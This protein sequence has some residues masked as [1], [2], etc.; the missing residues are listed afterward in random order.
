MPR[1]ICGIYPKLN[2]V[3]GPS[4]YPGD[5]G[6]PPPRFKDIRG[7]MNALKLAIEK[8][9]PSERPVAHYQLWGPHDSDVD[10]V[11]DCWVI[12][13]HVNPDYPPPPP[14]P[15]LPT[16]THSPQKTFILDVAA[17]PKAREALQRR[18]RQ[19]LAWRRQPSAI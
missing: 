19:G 8:A 10:G 18:R 5:D 11:P 1:A 17:T 4:M 7:Y 14:P 15:L 16:F 12:T 6:A 9:P 3:T 2:V 13:R